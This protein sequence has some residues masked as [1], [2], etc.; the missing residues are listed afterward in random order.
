M[1]SEDDNGLS[2]Q[3]IASTINTLVGWTMKAMSA[4]PLTR[5]PRTDDLSGRP[6]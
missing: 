1:G 6:I 3:T 4:P 5:T 2:I